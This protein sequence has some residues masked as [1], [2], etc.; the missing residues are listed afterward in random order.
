VEAIAEVAR[1]LVG[2]RDAW[3][4]PPNAS[5]EELNP[6]TLT[7]LYNAR[8][9]LLA[10]VHREFAGVPLAAPETL[11]HSGHAKRLLSLQPQQTDGLAAA[12]SQV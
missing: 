10:A 7:N 12:S 9:S 3:L 2:K 1:E 11:P 4:N 8:P 5:L 6:R